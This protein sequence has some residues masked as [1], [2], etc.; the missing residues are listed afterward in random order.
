MSLTEEK[1]KEVLGQVIDPALEHDIV[2]WRIFS[3]REV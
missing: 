2:S 1:V 3:P